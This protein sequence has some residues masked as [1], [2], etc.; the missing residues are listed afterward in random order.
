MTAEGRQVEWS[1]STFKK[2]YHNY[3]LLYVSGQV[4]NEYRDVVEKHREFKFHLLGV[5]SPL[6]KI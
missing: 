2:L 3:S 1:K 4:Y 5:L 6:C